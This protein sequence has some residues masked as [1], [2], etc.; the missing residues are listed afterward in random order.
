[1]M[2]FSDALRYIKEGQKLSRES[3]DCDEFIFMVAGSKFKVNRQ[4]LLSIF[5]LDTE[6]TYCPHIDINNQDGSISVWNP[7]Q[8][9]L[10]AEDYFILE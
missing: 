6:I 4:P 10:F 5:G 2:N 1:M 7:N 8:V 3:W 9:D